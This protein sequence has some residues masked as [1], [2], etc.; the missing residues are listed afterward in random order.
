MSK[1]VLVVGLGNP[2]PKYAGN[3]H[4]FG[5]MVADLLA[6]R[7]WGSFR[8]KFNGAL[9][10]VNVG[11]DSYTLLKPMTFMNLSGQSVSRAVQYFNFDLPDII[12]I[13]DELDLPFGTIRVKNGG[14]TAGHKGITSIKKELGDGGFLRIRMGIGRPERGSV[15]DF[16]L[17][18]F[19]SEERA[20]L[21]DVVARGADAVTL[22]VEKGPAFAMNQLNRKEG[23]SV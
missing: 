20:E 23:Q 10:R 18:D 21:D 12:I 8:D 6:A 19:N 16:V 17:K 14:G 9:A 22:L 15:S 1:D 5:F 3:R 7:H 4:N 11:L 13:H 2:G